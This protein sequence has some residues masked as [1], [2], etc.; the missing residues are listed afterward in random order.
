MIIPNAA[1]LTM[2]AFCAAL[3]IVPSACGRKAPPEPLSTTKPAMDPAIDRDR[4]EAPSAAT[5]G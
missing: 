1:K 3:A 2:A 5:G 4:Q